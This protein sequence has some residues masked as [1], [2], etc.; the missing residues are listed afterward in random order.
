[1]PSP[2]RL[3]L[4]KINAM[5][6]LIIIIGTIILGC[7]IFGMMYKDDNSIYA[8]TKDKLE[9]STEYLV[10]EPVNIAP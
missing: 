10:G 1:M 3:A 4:N 2:A 6:N 5:K 7:S 8:L 9:K